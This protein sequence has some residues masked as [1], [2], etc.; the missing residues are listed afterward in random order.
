MTFLFLLEREQGGMKKYLVAQ[1]FGLNTLPKNILLLGMYLMP[2]GCYY[3]KWVRDMK[4]KEK[5]MNNSSLMYL[6]K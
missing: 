4:D 6:H 3:W 5:R 1:Q 2:R